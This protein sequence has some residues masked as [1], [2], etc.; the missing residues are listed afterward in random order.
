MKQ[1][2]KVT[3]E[4]KAFA[5]TF[6]FLV[7]RGAFSVA[8]TKQIGDAFEQ[9]MTKEMRNQGM[10]RD[11]QL[12]CRFVICP[13]FCERHSALRAL[14]KDDRILQ[15]LEM[16]LG[17]DWFYKDSEA[18]LF[19]GPTDWH[20]DGGWAP[21]TPLW[22][23]DPNTEP[24]HL[25]TY[26]K[27]AIYPDPLTAESGCLRVIPGSHR[28]PIHESLASLHMDIPIEAPEM[29]TDPR[30]KRFG[31]DPCDVPS[32]AIE[33]QPSDIVFF[34]GH[35]WH[36]AFGGKA[37]RRNIALSFLSAPRNE[38]QRTYAQGINGR[39]KRIAQEHISNQ[40]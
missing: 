5:D 34:F 21:S 22:P 9:V 4:Q 27:V 40:S 25:L 6:G 29:A 37:G 13:G 24:H 19:V 36:S 20:P 32:F 2:F 12:E 31:I 26:V 7:L 14:T 35:T 33:T 38:G 18:N 17:P 30:F 39:A 23:S 11:Q 10:S 16:M 15:T 3:A 28:S 8:E 1:R